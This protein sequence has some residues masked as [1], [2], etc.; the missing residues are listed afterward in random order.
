MKRLFLSLCL[1]LTVFAGNS[2]AQ[3]IPNGSF[4]L[5]NVGSA[6]IENW[7]FQAINACT[8]S[9]VI[10][11]DAK[12]GVKALEAQITDIASGAASGSVTL[13]S[14]AFSVTSNKEYK[15]N[16]WAKAAN[17]NDSIAVLFLESNNNEYEHKGVIKLSTSWKK[18]SASYYSLGTMNL[19]LEFEFLSVANILLD[20]VVLTQNVSSYS[21]ETAAIDYTDGK[22]VLD[23]NANEAFWGNATRYDI[24][25]PFDSEEIG[26]ENPA[27][28]TSYW[29]AAYTD[30]GL[31]ILVNTT[32]DDVHKSD[33]V[34]GQMWE[35]DRTEIYFDM[36]SDNLQDG[37]GV[38]SGAALGHYQFGFD[39]ETDIIPQYNF[40]NSNYAVVLNPDNSYSQEV[41]IAWKD[42][43]DQYGVSYTFDSGL[44]IGFDVCIIDND[45]IFNGNPRYRK[46]W[47]NNGLGSSLVE[48][49]SSMDDAGVLELNPDNSD[50]L[51]PVTT[52]NV[53]SVN[54]ESAITEYLGSLQL[55]ADVFP[56]D[57]T[58]R[59]VKW[60]VSDPSIAIINTSGTLQAL[61]NGAVIVSATARDG[62]TVYG[63]FDVTIN[64]DLPLA[65]YTFNQTLADVTGQNSIASSLSY[66]FEAN[67]INNYVNLSTPQ[68][69]GSAINSFTVSYQLNTHSNFGG[70][71]Y[72]TNGAEEIGVIYKSGKYS[73]TYG[74]KSYAGNISKKDGG[75][76]TIKICF[77]GKILKLFV[78]EKFAC[79]AIISLSDNSAFKVSSNSNY[80]QALYSYVRDLRIFS[81]S[82]AAS[83]IASYT[84][85]GNADDASGNDYHGTVSGA[86]LIA[87]RYLH[88][89]SAYN[90]NGTNNNITT[91][92]A[93]ILGSE[94][95]TISMWVKTNDSINWQNVLAYG[96][97]TKGNAF[98]CNIN[99]NGKQGINIDIDTASILYVAKVANGSWHHVAWALPK[100]ANP[101]LQDV[102]VYFDG[103]LLTDV[104]ESNEASTPIDTKAGSNLI[105]GGID[106][107]DSTSYFKGVL[108]EVNIFTGEL[109]EGEIAAMAA[110]CPK[111][112]PYLENFEG[113]FPPKGLAFSGAGSNGGWWEDYKWI[114]GVK[115]KVIYHNT[116][117]GANTVIDMPSINLTDADSI[118]FE[119]L[120]NQEYEDSKS[121]Q[122]KVKLYVS[123]DQGK[124]F[125]DAPLLDFSSNTR[126]LWLRLTADLK[127]Y[128]GKIVNLKIVFENN[129]EHIFIDDIKVSKF[130]AGAPVVNTL[131]ATN[132]GIYKATLKASVFANFNKT[133]VKFEFGESSIGLDSTVVAISDSIDAQGDVFFNLTNLK[134]NTLYSFRAIA[135]NKYD[136]VYGNTLQF[137][138]VTPTDPIDSLALVALY[139]STAGNNW[140]YNSNWLKI[141]VASWNGI[142]TKAGRV[143]GI[144]LNN[145]NLDGQIPAE[146]VNLSKL[147]SLDLSNNRIN[148][149]IPLEI[150]KLS[151]LIFLYLNNNYT[152]SG[153]IPEEIGNLTNLRY[154]NLSDN[155]FSGELPSS[156]GNM[157]SLSS[158]DLNGNQ[159]T[160]SLPKELGNLTNLRYLYIGSNQLTG[161]I[162]LELGNLSS[163]RSL[164]LFNNRF[165]GEVPFSLFQISGLSLNI[166]SN[167]FS[168]IPDLSY[169]PQNLDYLDA[170]Y[171]NLTF[172]DFEYNLGIAHESYIMPQERVGKVKDVVLKIGEGY[173]INANV[174]GENNIYRW[175]KDGMSIAG[176]SSSY[177]ITNMDV[178]KV[179]SYYCI[180][181]NSLVSGTIE[182]NVVNI[183]LAPDANLMTPI[184]KLSSPMVIDGQIDAKWDDYVKHPIAKKFIWDEYGFVNSNDLMAY[185]QAAWCDSGV[186][187]LANITKDDVHSADGSYGYAREQD[188]VE[189]YFDL[190]SFN[191]R[192]G[193]GIGSGL[194]HIQASYS[195]Q[196]S[197]VDLATYKA[198]TVNNDN[199]YFTEFFVPWRDLKDIN[200]DAFVPVVGNFFGFDVNVSD[201]D[202]M[203]N[204]SP[205]YRMAWANNAKNY[206]N[207][208]SMDDA[209][210]LLLTD[211]DSSVI[212][213]QPAALTYGGNP[214]DVAST[215]TGLP[216]LLSSSDASILKI[217]GKNG[218]IKGAG[219]VLI[220]ATI[221]GKDSAYM[222]KQITVNKAPLT[223]TADNKWKVINKTNPTL[224]FSYSGFVNGDDAGSLIAPS[225]ST[226][227]LTASPIGEYAITFS[228]GLAANYVFTFVNGKLTITQPVLTITAKDTSK[229]YGQSNPLFELEYSGFI[230]GENADNITKP[231]VSCSANAASTPGNFDIV[232]SGGSSDKYTL[233]RINGVLKVNKAPLKIEAKDTAKIYGSANPA[234]RISCSG[235][236]ND[237]NVNSIT[238]PVSSTEA[239]ASSNVGNYDILLSGG[240]SDKYVLSLTNAKLSVT[241]ASL[242]VLAKDTSKFYGA[243][244]P[245]FA[246]NY[247]GFVN[248][249]DTSKIV[250]PSIVCSAT[251]SSPAG[252]Y[253][254][255]LTGGN[256][257]NYVFN[258]INGKLSVGKVK[259]VLTAKDTSKIYGTANPDF[260]IISNGFVNGDKLSSITQPQFKCNADKLSAV[261]DYEI[262]LEGGASDSY[263]LELNSGIL[264]VNKAALTAKAIDTAKMEKAA[265]PV[266][267]I[268]Y[269]GFV[270]NES[271]SA[272][273]ALPL[274]SCTATETSA[275]GSYDI[276]LSGGGDNNYYFIYEN[277]SLTVEPSNSI[278]LGDNSAMSV[279]P[280]PT[281]DVLN[282]K[283]LKSS[284]A[285]V[286]IYNGQGQLVLVSKLDET[287]RIDVRALKSGLYTIKLF[288]NDNY[289]VSNFMKK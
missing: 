182:T 256:S 52:I 13:R 172:E 124:T 130:T 74:N 170:S 226:T 261:G 146:I 84:F 109:T 190:N 100:M 76:D 217:E 20:S 231:S 283:N 33:N 143:V 240:S 242:N 147:Q 142:E 184:A 111:S 69:L 24:V 122:N 179:G 11:A 88:A 219:S 166:C 260:S 139:N 251:T 104:L 137:L 61:R 286:Q 105:I 66:S 267:R 191:L 246:I 47:V 214:F 229:T 248:G 87:D 17:A 71:F 21:R 107:T 238:M 200:G 60:T 68:I 10:S 4:E 218:A 259:L 241:K 39:A 159:L 211:V 94:A 232:V 113:E 79:N 80:W 280:N 2:F 221:Q 206:E 195:S 176:T 212:I 98:R 22:L 225:I 77:D 75:W 198:V 149:S 194:G 277:G 174:G 205:R 28:L 258:F 177:V 164:F 154:L 208:A 117:N 227:A 70:G 148:G 279:Y 287:Q 12:S 171:N 167:L 123:V 58:R 276:V 178:S 289:S 223:I 78:N 222:S 132:V 249:D 83:T 16:F 3:L 42:L 64:M 110:D 168:S 59:S 239:T 34:Y 236:V 197:I 85:D 73:L 187:V 126:Q 157:F 228:G 282:I 41:F 121:S 56:L 274:A 209:G 27:D 46:I 103:N 201:N 86:S 92:Y 131:M 129:T 19:K 99:Y 233:N 96:D 97:A 90:F 32:A 63:D 262:K 49:W 278:A 120:Y 125:G 266:F 185:W 55:A 156:I 6:A 67:Y 207:W 155:F 102:K 82:N 285:R 118:G 161:S 35:Q 106:F 50:I 235:F 145:N 31:F 18:Y 215:N 40:P 284:N 163:L 181:S 144:N 57:A 230:D 224:T 140:H 5:N 288:D 62:S 93:G 199:S 112:I 153:S 44:P 192:D 30:S 54:G 89:D 95:R 119:L 134:S 136:T 116:W 193:L 72:I 250:K 8:A 43:K 252:I 151:N 115:S 14:T 135:I 48:D 152:L 51:V 29:K 183:G 196:T 268:K 23:G 173:T 264:T 203:G 1:L 234:F 158:L 81:K 243:E 263:T 175:Y 108:D 150:G 281:H 45:D 255:S 244:N 245:K 133:A 213:N 37:N 15:L 180:I 210:I 165:S 273:D 38:G 9:T 188:G 270:N 220:T 141:E 202:G 257:S 25:R 271:I 138:T 272:I 127:P 26:F 275:A 53:S 216:L 65:H 253:D 269:S 128:R 247:S 186:F 254:I 162:P 114:D 91:S 160:G 237:D 189:V 265:N 101:K 36:N 7:T 204:G 169:L